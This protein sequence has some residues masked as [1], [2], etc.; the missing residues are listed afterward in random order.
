MA[1]GNKVMDYE[2]LRLIMKNMIQTE[3]EPQVLNRAEEKAKGV[4]DQ[5]AATNSTTLTKLKLMPE[6]KRQ[7]DNV[8]FSKVG[9][10][11]QFKH[12]TEVLEKIDDALE[13]METTD[14][15]GITEAVTEAK[16]RKSCLYL[17]ARRFLS[18]KKHIAVS[19]N[20]S[21]FPAGNND[22]V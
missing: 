10:Y 5:T 20:S 9:H 22:F 17:P 6:K 15:V 7:N 11:D 3:L 2:Q 4:V 14:V 18:R 21:N 13:A 8:S 19:R 1:E 12:N 16:R